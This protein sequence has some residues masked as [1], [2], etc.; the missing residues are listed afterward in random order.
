MRLLV[1]ASVIKADSI[2]EGRHFQGWHGSLNSILCAASCI[3]SEE[4]ALL[5]VCRV[6]ADD[7]AEYRQYT[8]QRFGPHIDYSAVLADPLGTNVHKAVHTEEGE[9]VWCDHVP[10]PISFADVA[11]YLSPLPDAVLLNGGD[12][13]AF[14]DD[15]VLRLRQQLPATLI[16]VD[17]HRM[18]NQLG[19]DHILEEPGWAGWSTSCA[20]ADVVQGARHEWSACTG[21]DVQDIASARLAIEMALSDGA[22]A[23]ICTLGAN[24]CVTGEAL[25][26]LPD[27]V[28]ASTP[29]VYVDALGGGDCLQVGYVKARLDGSSHLRAVRLG[30]SFASFA[31]EHL[32]HPPRGFTT[33]A[34]VIARADATYGS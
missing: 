17:I 22:R 3:L 8:S 11:P 33:W 9:R 6:G 32:E 25:D 21:L 24:G 2:V 5:P 12:V 14:T 30:C 34:E 29:R 27:Y 16:Y 13:N 7:V 28:P 26:R 10:T 4:D 18:V 19:E 23:A 20:T 15:L 1:I 31:C